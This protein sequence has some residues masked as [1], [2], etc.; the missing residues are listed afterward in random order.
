MKRFVSIFLSILII[1][2][3]SCSQEEIKESEALT[4][5]SYNVQNLFD[6]LEVGT[7]YYEFKRH[8]GWTTELYN[9]RISIF[10]QLFKGDNYADA[11]VI[12]LEEVESR[13]VLV[14]LL[15]RG[16]R[17]RGFLYYGIIEDDNPIS[18]G[19]ISK[20]SPKAVSVHSVGEQRPILCLELVKNNQQFV[21]T[22]LHAKSNVGSED[23]CM[24]KRKEYARHISF[25]TEYYSR[26]PLIIIGDFNTEPRLD[27]C[28]MLA[29]ISCIN[30]S[31]ALS[32]GCVPITGDINNCDGFVLYDL[33]YD[34]SIPLSSDGSYYYNGRWYIYDRA[35]V[36]RTLIDCSYDLSF[37]I[38]GDETASEYGIPLSFERA[39]GV[40]FSDHFAVKLRVSF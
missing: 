22:C 39:S 35:L 4:I 36:N 19:Y 26:T 10:Q 38:L 31:N 40:G 28:D 32:E 6:D 9:K 14:A 18:V 8:S 20:I 27:T 2:F 25:L 11:D 3:L 21:I 30:V 29:D 7:E 23:E 1:F 5:I 24:K 13:E 17:M 37:D 12:F 15:D 33:A 16:L 34:R